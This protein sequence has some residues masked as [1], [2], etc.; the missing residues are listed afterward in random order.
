[1]NLPTAVPATAL[2]SVRIVGFTGHR[3]VKHP[4]AVAELIRKE[5]PSLRPKGEELIAMSSIAIGADTIFV[6]EALRA[7]LKWVAMLPM[8]REIFRQDFTPEEWAVAEQ[9]LAQAAEIRTIHGH[10]RPQGYVDCGKATVDE[11]DIIMSLWDGLPARGAGGTAEI[12][13]YARS[14]GREIVLFHETD[15]AVEKIDSNQISAAQHEPDVLVRSM[16]TMP[17]VPPL[18]AALESQFAAADAEANLTAP[19]FR[20]TKLRMSGYNLAASV[21]AGLGFALSARSIWY[22]TLAFTGVKLVFLF[23][24]FIAT[25]RLARGRTRDIWLRQ[26]LIAEYCRSILATWH[27]RDFIEP[28]SQH[29]FPEIRELARAALF[30][31]LGRDPDEQIDAKSFRAFYARKRVLHQYN[32]FTDQVEKAE[33]EVAPLRERYRAYTLGAFILGIILFFIHLLLPDYSSDTYA[34]MPTYFRINIFIFDMLPMVLPAMAAFVLTRIAVRELDRRIGR[35]KDLQQKMHTALVD[36]SFC[37]SWTSLSKTVDRTEK[38][39]F[40]EVMEWYSIGK[41]SG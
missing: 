11:S 30:L 7:G 12:V 32:Y 15:T 2:P 5:L 36:L 4:E 13:A 33:A 26:R 25:K 9:L 28:I 3:V 18:P 39:L 40:H 22:P 37:G 17:T 1:M 31:R 10:E 8:S 21:I 29:A 35:Y 20:R 23:L 41:F 19:N 34:W 6:Q 14:V 27:C 38:I 16:G 24:A